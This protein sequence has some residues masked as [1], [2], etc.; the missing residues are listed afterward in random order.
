MKKL[1]PILT[2]CFMLLCA[3]CGNNSKEEVAAFDFENT[4][5]FDGYEFFVGSHDTVSNNPNLFI[6][7]GGTLHEGGSTFALLQVA[8][9]TFVIQPFPGEDWTAV[10][11]EGDTAVLQQN[12][13]QTIIVCLNPEDPE[14]DTLWMYDPGDMTPMAAYESL[15]L[16]RRVEAL[17]G[18]YFDAKKKITYTFTDTFLIRTDA[19]GVAD[20]QSFHFFYSFEMPS[21]LLQLSN[22]EQFWYE[23]TPK[24]MDLFNAKLWSEEEDYI[25]QTRFAQL[26]RQ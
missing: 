2:T 25:R 11:V 3:A 7:K 15:L 22:K 10:G 12:G 26:E 19:K 6:F 23:F 18:T 1:F 17:A 4:C 21:H 24:G 14:S 8:Q 16:Q 13:G 9:D 5:W 20:T